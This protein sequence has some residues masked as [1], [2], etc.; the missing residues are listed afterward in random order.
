MS[1][2][3]EMTLQDFHLDGKVYKYWVQGNQKNPP[4]ILFY[5]YTGVHKDFLYL[6]E[7]LKNNYFIIIPEF[8]G[9]NKSPRLDK[10]LTI[11]N[12]A[13]YF[14]SLFDFL[15][16][17][18][19]NL[20]GHCFGAV[21]AIEYA[22]FYPDTVNKLILVSPPYLGGK[23]EKFHKFLVRM[24]ENSPKF[25]RPVFFFWRSRILA[26]P[27]DFYAIKLRSFE[28][29]MDR[30]KEHIFKQ[31]FEPEDAV[32]ENWIS[33]IKFNF[34]KVKRINIR[35][36]LIHGAGDVLVNIKQAEKL[37]KLFPHATLDIISQAGHVPPVEAPD[38]LLE[39]VTKYLKA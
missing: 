30:V 14:K 33:F 6:A 12:Y 9:W 18:K 15:G 23:T 27:F 22:Y 37:Q 38:E 26:V 7:K 16:F 13:K 2:F 24:A 4:L 11:N 35:A 1:N 10:P 29:K 31:F 19:I 34:N 3:P 8:P 39:L 5:G 25:I 21:V 17:S 32:E 36:N 20:F 28:K